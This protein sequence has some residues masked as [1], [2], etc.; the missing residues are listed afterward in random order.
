MSEPASRRVVVSGWFWGQLATGSGQYVHALVE[1]LPEVGASDTYTLVLPKARFPNGLEDGPAIHGAW[2]CRLVATPFD[3]IDENL[4]KLWF[5]QVS[6]PYLCRRIRA[7]LAFVPYWGA[8]AWHPCRVAV[9]VHDLIPLLLADYRGG[10]LQRAYTR[11]VGWTARRADLVLT[12]S[13]SSR[14]DLVQH[15][16]IPDDKA[17]AVL[18]AAGSHYRPIADTAVLEAVRR[19]YDL[20]SHFI[21][22]LGGFD[23]RKNVVRLVQAYARLVHDPS[24]QDPDLGGLD[25]VESDAIPRLVIA[26][27]L[28]A[29]DSAFAPDPRLAAETAGVADRVRFAG[30]VDEADKPAIYNLA[31]VFV[32]PSLYE[33]FGLPVAEA[34]ACGVRVVT[35]DRSSLPEVA[36]E[37]ILVDPEDETGLARGIVQA[38]RAPAQPRKRSARSWRDV[39]AETARVWQGG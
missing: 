30:W 3:R 11:L 10:R 4:A 20:P 25:S 37:A 21:L 35:S 2:Q 23:V 16:G 27:S 5:E 1:Y 26:G 34:A 24:V 29:K 14:S 36:P 19:R 13:Q 17:H 9:T 38:L 22:Y 15:L 32:F 33:G 8:P 31:D 12:D 18:L 6:F 39:A 28:P 7:D